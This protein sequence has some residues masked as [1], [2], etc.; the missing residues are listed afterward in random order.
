MVFKKFT[1][2]LAPPTLPVGARGR[3]R[4]DPR[5]PLHCTGDLSELEVLAVVVAVL[6][7]PLRK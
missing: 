6:L 7:H 5:P 2:F 1:Y 4:Q 3:E